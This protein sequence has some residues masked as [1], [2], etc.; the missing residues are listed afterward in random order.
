MPYRES[1]PLKYGWYS[2]EW[3]TSEE[4]ME[5]VLD[6]LWPFAQR[7]FKAANARIR[8][9]EKAN[10]TFTPALDAIN[11]SGGKF[12]LARPWGDNALNNV[13]MNVFRA[14]DFMNAKTSTL[15]GARKF[16]AE[17]KMKIAGDKAAEI[18]RSK[19]SKI[20]ELYRKAEEANFASIEMYGSD[21]VVGYI[22]KSMAE[23]TDDQILEG[24]EEILQKEYETREEEM[25]RALADDIGLMF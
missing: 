9:I 16:D 6:E 5:M 15:R 13:R 24:L 2:I 20:W 22:Y 7:V 23:M 1:G 18:S 19:A 10:L 12:S 4:L 14:R 3:P 21:N 11:N 25:E 17:M 8:R